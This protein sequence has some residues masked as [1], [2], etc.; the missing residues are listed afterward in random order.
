LAKLSSRDHLIQPLAIGERITLNNDVLWTNAHIRL[1]V[2]V[3]QTAHIRLKYTVNPKMFTIFAIANAKIIGAK[4]SSLMH[5]ELNF[6][7]NR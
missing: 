5:F 4:I 2:N 1:A 3:V 7:G 6:H